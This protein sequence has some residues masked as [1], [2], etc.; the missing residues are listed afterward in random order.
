M[1]YSVES[2]DIKCSGT[3]GFSSM[4]VVKGFEPFVSLRPI[5]PCL[6]G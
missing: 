3:N 4:C 5:I 6:I 1:I 2:F